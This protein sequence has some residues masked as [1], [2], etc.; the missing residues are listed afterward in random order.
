MII[1][2]EPQDSMP[3]KLGFLDN[4]KFKLVL[5]PFFFALNFVPMI[6]IR[7]FGGQM[8]SFYFLFYCWVSIY[9][10]FIALLVF[11]NQTAEIKSFILSS[12]GIAFLV[13]LTLATR[14]LYLGSGTTLSL[15]TLWYLDYGKLMLAGHMP[16]ADFYFL[17]PPVFGYFIMI[18]TYILPTTDG[19]RILSTL[20]DAGIVVVIWEIVR[21]REFYIHQEILPIAYSL[22]PI[23]IIESGLNG[24]FEPIANLALLIG[25]WCIISKRY[26]V[27]SVMIGL[28]AATKIYALFLMPLLLLIIP[29]TREKLR[30]IILTMATVFLTFIPFSIPVWLR[31]DVVFPGM[32]M[33]GNQTGFLDST[34]GFLGRINS[35]QLSFFSV[36]VLSIALIMGYSLY[37]V[38]KRH[39]HGNVLSYNILT[40]GLG[41]TLFLMSL[42]A[43][44][45]PFTGFASEA[46]WR[47]P[48]DI[49]L[50]KGAIGMILSGLTICIAIT[51]QFRGSSRSIEPKEVVLIG[52]VLILLILSLFRQAFFGWYFLWCLMPLLLIRDK[53]ILFTVFV[54]ILI[55]YP[56]YTSDNFQALGFSEQRVWQDS[57]DN[58]SG[59][60]YAIEHNKIAMPPINVSAFS[61]N[62]I[63]VF[64]C[65]IP[66]TTNSTQL[67]GVTIVWSTNTTLSF[68]LGM[69]FVV[70]ISVSWNPATTKWADVYMKYQ[71]LDSGHNP[72]NGTILSNNTLYTNHSFFQWR[73]SISGDNSAAPIEF[74]QLSLELSPFRAGNMSILVKDMYAI[75]DDV[76]FY[77]PLQSL[78]LVVPV[79]LSIFVLWKVLTDTSFKGKSKAADNQEA[80]Q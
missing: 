62:G 24:H 28:S 40:L 57:M 17:Y 19:F 35:L 74:T 1:E 44:V 53:R 58:L 8:Y 16:Y 60:T 72:I 11:Y 46:L 3:R 64:S 13:V 50:I 9:V 5:L 42:V 4:K 2:N 65:Q 41:V 69:S 68:H 45:Y 52:S 26:G 56:T 10:I 30:S 48:G 49:S 31:G 76:L 47:Y 75:N 29:T 34:F 32:P 18:V 27:G 39:G 77:Y 43:A 63:G 23:S 20:F 51:R 12:G 7:Y 22:L 71:G 15:D 36:L 66:S 54:C 80:L 21:K 55:L 73:Y 61:K 25:L 79:G 14:F 78:L 6:L 37:K 67:E 70:D 38:F 59:W 33:P